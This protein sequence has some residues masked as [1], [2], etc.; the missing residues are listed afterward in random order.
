VSWAPLR[1]AGRRLGWG[2]A[3]QGVSSLTNFAVNIYIAREL[4]AAEYGAF[5]LA[6]V[7]Y[8]FA[9]NASRGLATDPLLVRFSYT[10]LPTWRRAVASCT[11]TA[12]VVGLATGTCVL[13]AALVLGGSTRLAFLALGLTLPGLMLQDSWRFAFFAKGRGSHAFLN[14]VVWLVT[15]VPALVL[16]KATHHASVFWFVLAWGASATVAA[17][18]GP[19]QAHVMPRLPEVWEWLSR[20]RDLGFRYMVEG[21]TNSAATQLRNY[22]IGLI[23]GLAAVG[24]VQAAST[25]MGPFMVIITGSGLIILPEAAKMWRDSPS[26]L[27][28]YCIIISAVYTL[29]G[30]AWGAVLLLALPRGLGSGL[31]GPI[32][33]PSYPLVLPTT[34]SI[35]GLCVTSGAGTGLHAAGAARQSLRAA[36]LTSAIYVAC[37]VAGAVEGGAVGAVEGTAVATW[38]GA[39]VYWWQLSSA[40]RESGRTGGH[41][42]WTGRSSGKHRAADRTA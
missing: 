26:R 39:L 34:I 4:G 2:V 22:G 33:R 13:L 25:L 16:L 40:L 19:L 8:A 36:I 35:M 41:R 14:D 5:S 30:L 7:T 9:L 21:T 31:L 32:W 27:P 1:R 15:L 42:L 10:D 12:A 17:A 24:Y 23:L 38:L 11:G 29:L 3:D 20:Q 28:K 6:Y 18:V 37:S